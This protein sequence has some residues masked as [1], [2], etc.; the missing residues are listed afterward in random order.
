MRYGYQKETERRKRTHKHSFITYI[1]AAVVITI[2]IV[3]IIIIF[4]FF[5][6]I[7]LRRQLPLACL[8]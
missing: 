8:G 7:I 5:L 3:N 1:I 6:P 4:I 2:I